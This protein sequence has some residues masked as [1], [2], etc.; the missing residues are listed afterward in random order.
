MSSLQQ[1]NPFILSMIISDY[2][3]T[4]SK[5]VVNPANFVKNTTLKYTLL[6]MRKFIREFAYGS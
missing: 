2:F 1:S 3:V 5:I 4:L 6:A